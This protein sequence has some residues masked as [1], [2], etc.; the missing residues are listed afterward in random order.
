MNL[1]SAQSQDAAGCVGSKTLRGE[2]ALNAH[3]PQ[4]AQK[5]RAA[6]NGAR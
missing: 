2:F 3:G 4:D 5:P 6:I 1:R